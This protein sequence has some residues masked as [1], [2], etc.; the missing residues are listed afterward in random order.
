ML[1]GEGELEVEAEV[2][3]DGGI[4]GGG[5]EGLVALTVVEEG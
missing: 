5:E 2:L 1:S 3:C 4:S